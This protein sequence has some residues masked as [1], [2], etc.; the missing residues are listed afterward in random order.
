MNCPIC[1]TK[2][3]VIDTRLRLSGNMYRRHKCP[4]CGHKFTS[5]EIIVKQEHVPKAY[6]R[7][8]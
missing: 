8:L 4:N 7:R 6:I 1:N 5:R 3:K 2:A